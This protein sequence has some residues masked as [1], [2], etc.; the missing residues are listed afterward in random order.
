MLPAGEISSQATGACQLRTM[1]GATAQQQAQ[2][3]KN[4]IWG[5]VMKFK[6][7]CCMD[8][9]VRAVNYLKTKNIK[10]ETGPIP[11]RIYFTIYSDTESSE[12]FLDYIQTLPETTISKSSVFSKEEM[13]SAQWY[14]LD[15]YR[16]GIDTSNVK[17]TYDAK[18]PY[19]TSYGMQKHHHLDQINPFVSKRTPKWKNGYQ[20]CSVDTGNTTRIFCSDYAK[21]IIIK[22]GITGLDFMPVLKGDLITQ[23]PDVSQ[24]VF[25]H[26]LPLEAYT[27]I[28]EYTEKICPLCGRINYLFSEP[29]CDNIRLNTD[30]IPEGID[31]FGSQIVLGWGFGDEPIVIS[32]KFYNLIVKEL[33][34]KTG[35]ITCF[36]IG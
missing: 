26:K 29:N 12:E 4:D 27:F 10:Y 30:I 35:H 1:H 34:E 31:A 2:L 20:F 36:P 18:C 3:K 33:K 32:K 28:G 15:V 6:F 14:L 21:E 23:T 11:K 5:I 8:E 9:D 16:T 22:S 25:T 24:L 13:E 17:F 19:I 7:Y